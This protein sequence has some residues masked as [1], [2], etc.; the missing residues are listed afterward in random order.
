MAMFEGHR[1]GL[2]SFAPANKTTA[3]KMSITAPNQP[4]FSEIRPKSYGFEV[5]AAAVDDF[6]FWL[7]F[8]FFGSVNCDIDFQGE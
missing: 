1:T 8:F 3:R 4:G 6:L 2:S 7:E 5:T